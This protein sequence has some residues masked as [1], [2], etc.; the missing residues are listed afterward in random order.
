M[1]KLIN[2]TLLRYNSDGT[3]DILNTSSLNSTS[4]TLSFV[5]PNAYGNQTFLTWTF[6]NNKFA[7]FDFIDF[8]TKALDIFGTFGAVLAGIVVLAIGLIA[9]SEGVVLIVALVLGLITVSMMYLIDLSWMALVSI[10][11]AGAI[12]VYRL[13]KRRSA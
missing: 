11:C 5:V 10:I 12:I 7:S 8:K 1:P 4:G 2:F 6:V 13:I 3:T 9:I